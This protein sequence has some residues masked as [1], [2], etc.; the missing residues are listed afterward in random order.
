MKSQLNEVKKLQRLAGILKEDQSEELSQF[1]SGKKYP[2]FSNPLEGF[3]TEYKELL[4]KLQ[5]SNDSDERTMLINK[6]NVIRKNMKLKPLTKED[7]GERPYSPGS[8]DANDW[9]SGLDILI[10]SQLDDKIKQKIIRELEKMGI[11]AEFTI[12]KRTYLNIPFAGDSENAK[13]VLDKLGIK[14]Q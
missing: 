4:K 10:K 6:M 14:Y 3:S 1:P 7:Q 2:S 5:R 13:S 9:D 11:E 8:S 12:G